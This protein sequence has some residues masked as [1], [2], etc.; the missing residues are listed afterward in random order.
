MHKLPLLPTYQVSFS[1]C[2]SGQVAHRPMERLVQTGPALNAEE[3]FLVLIAVFLKPISTGLSFDAI[4][5]TGY[6]FMPLG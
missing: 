6:I 4:F 2:I 1:L 5:M 3:H